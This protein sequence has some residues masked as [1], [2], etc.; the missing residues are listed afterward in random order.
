MVLR[1]IW[2][3]ALIALATIALIS[4][5]G[6]KFNSTTSANVAPN[7]AKRVPVIVELF[8]SEGCSDCPPADALLERLQS[9]QP[10]AGAE[11]IVLGNHVD[12]WNH[13]GWTDRF[14]TRELTQRQEAYGTSFNLDSV[15]TPQMVVDGKAEFNGQD[16]S[17]AKRAVAAA[18]NEP[19]AN[20]SIAPLQD[21]LNIQIDSIPASAKQA[22]V[23]LAITED[24]L[25]SNV[26]KGENS[27][28]TLNHS[29]VVRDLR[30]IG[31]AD[32]N[33]FSA[34]P[35]VKLDSS[36]KRPDLHAVVFIQD[37]KTQHILG[38]ASLLFTK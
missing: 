12:Y 10:V 18:I 32:G 25:Q 1:R 28:R 6:A 19:K 35:K 14:S 21:A 34:Q 24:H 29:G 30:K 15:Y 37:A 20:I 8:T 23:F 27:G 9:T 38:A 22:Q 4:S 17:R 16:E 33:S 26:G 36:W 11:I 7:T 2:I 3:F 13:D 31:T 5:L